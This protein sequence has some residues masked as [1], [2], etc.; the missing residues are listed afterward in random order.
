MAVDV[1]KTAPWATRGE[2]PVTEP[3]AV[4]TRVNTGRSEG[5]APGAL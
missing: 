5:H 3:L 1:E 2:G 4:A